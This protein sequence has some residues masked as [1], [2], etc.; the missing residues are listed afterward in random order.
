MAAAADW[1]GAEGALMI[2][3]TISAASV[4]VTAFARAAFFA[5][6]RLTAT[7]LVMI[8]PILSWDSQ[9]SGFSYQFSYQD[10]ARGF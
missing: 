8:A 4:A 6:F 5:R 2:P 3:T 10:G 9:L 1:A 7:R